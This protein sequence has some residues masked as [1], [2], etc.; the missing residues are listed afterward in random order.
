[1]YGLRGFSFFVVAILAALGLFGWGWN[2]VKLLGMLD[3]GVTA[4]FVVR[5]VGVFV[6]PLGGIVGYL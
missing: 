6:A 4:V 1:M 2:V 5:I 3:G